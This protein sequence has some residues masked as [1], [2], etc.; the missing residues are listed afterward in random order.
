MIG[1]PRSIQGRL[2]AWVLGMVVVVWLS[3]AGITWFDAR[4][5]LE[6]LLDGH[7]AQAASLLVV[8][9]QG[10]IEDDRHDLDA[11]T[12]HRY[13]P[14][15]AFQV[16]H[17]GRLALRS[18]NAPA[19]PM[20][21]PGQ[22]FRVGFDTVQIDGLTWRV[23]AAQGGEQDV[24]VYVGEQMNSRMGILWAV[25][26]STLW[27]MLVALPLLA[28][29][30]WW[31]VHLGVSPMRR[32]GQVL[33]QREPQALHPVAVAGATVEMLPMIEALNALF[34]RIDQLL[35]S[36][37]RFTA[38]AAHELRTPIAA[39]RA[40]AQVALAEADE[41]ARRHALL[42]TVQ[43]C[44]RATRL[45]DQLLTLS[46]LEAAD[47]MAPQVVDLRALT[48]SVLAELAPKALGKHQTLEFEAPEPCFLPGHETLLAVLV[49]NLV[50]NAVRYS[51]PSARVTVALRHEAG[52]VVLSVEDSGPGLAEA[53][54]QRLGER[55]FRVPGSLESGSG[56][57]W[58]IVQRIAQV[59]RLDVLV[60]P[61]RQLGGLAVRVSG[62]ASPA[63]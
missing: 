2:L 4:H 49:R 11:P 55:F 16:F 10:E 28:L 47:A 39:I 63:P 32:L 61:S 3:T 26:R 36:E 45:V 25:L 56:L 12:L 19:V 8:Q 52:R 30:V 17:E 27:P 60:E 7:L 9:Q 43:G 6:E 21:A 15:V 1:P 13:A 51:P 31:A 62:A 37:R 50:D 33:A 41:L 59:H 57:G 53:D 44:D 34:A 58:S 20:A 29:A 46:R 22:P 38:D 14:K 40:Q 5:E 35:A 42:N 18:A 23:F 48:Q 54:R 24:R